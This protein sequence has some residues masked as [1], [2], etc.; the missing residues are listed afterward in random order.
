MDI[1]KSIEATLYI[2]NR[3]ETCDIHKLFKILY[4][5]DRNHL[6]DYGRP[7][8]G[9]Y[10]VAMKNGPVPSFIYDVV[11]FVRGDKNYLSI[12][13]NVKGDFDVLDGRYIGAK[14][15]ANT[16]HLSGS[17]IECLD[18]AIKEYKDFGFQQLTKISHD[19][20]WEKADY[21]GEISVFDIATAA[22]AK[23]EML[24]YIQNNIGNQNAFSCR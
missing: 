5:S 15:D 8:T 23:I 2:L 24:K 12:D 19:D 1:D 7:V 4:F 20:A 11:K 18:K 13:R 3:L 21:N 16:D 10:Y 22:G 14:R 17:D 6:C 9:D